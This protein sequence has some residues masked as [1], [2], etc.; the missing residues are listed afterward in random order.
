ML[1]RT[2]LLAGAVGLSL[3]FLASPNAASA[4]DS[5][6]VCKVYRTNGQPVEGEVIEYPDKYEVKQKGPG[7]KGGV[8]ITIPKTQVTKIETVAAAAAGSNAAASAGTPGK[9]PVITDAMIA[10]VLGSENIDAASLDIEDKVQVDVM[11]PP[12]PPDESSIRD[13]LRIAGPQA[14]RL[15][16]DHFVFIYTSDIKL[17][18]EM[19][20]RLEGVYRWAAWFNE[21][22]GVK[23]TRP[24]HKLEIFFFGTFAEYDSY[25]TTNGF[26]MAGA[27]GFYMRTNNRS[28]FFDMMTYPPTV[29][30]LEAAKSAGPDERRRIQ[31]RVKRNVEN[32]NR[33]VVQH[34]A[35][36]HIH[37]NLGVFPR[38][39]D[40]P[41]W[42]SEGLA[43]MFE[44]VNAESGTSYGGLNH[45][46]LYEFRQIY[47]QDG[48]RIP[49]LRVI[50]LANQWFFQ[51]GFYAYS[52]GWAL[53]HYL[54]HA[55]KH[56]EKYKEW[57]RLLA[58]RDDDEQIPI[59]ELHQ[60]FEKLFGEIND[61]WRK[62]FIA[63]IKEQQLKMSEVRPD[64]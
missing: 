57:M 49:D 16:T 37:F 43:T 62:E 54:A 51:N 21:K 12:L 2:M 50:V 7:G 44:T 41:R 4:Q 13:M 24:P 30:D 55:P 28:A 1:H 29:A 48:E 42:M 31:N 5:R 45:Q 35:A 38:K 20:T 34:E 11:T 3:L 64:P 56:K 46:R 58:G 8:T 33:S 25:Q 10:E 59:A 26:R 61:D 22:N 32:Y 47:G 52:M 36:H 19:A 40:I 6:G 23:S 15:E 9:R 39:G 14:K 53:N 17:A 18:K 63:F 60:Q 27:I